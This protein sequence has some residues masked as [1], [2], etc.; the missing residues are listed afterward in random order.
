MVRL[1]KSYRVFRRRVNKVWSYFI[2]QVLKLDITEIKQIHGIKM[3][4]N[5]VEKGGKVY[6]SRSSYQ[7][8]VNPFYKLV[9]NSYMPDLVIDVGANYG[10]TSTLFSKIFTDAKIIAIEPAKNLCKYIDYNSRIND[11]KNITVMRAICDE[12]HGKQKRIS[13]NPLYSQDNRVKAPSKFWRNENV[14]TTSIDHILNENPPTHFLFVKID[15]QGFEYQVFKGARQ[16]LSKQRNWLIKTEFSPFC[17]EEQDTDPALFLEYLIDNY[18]VVDISGIMYFKENKILNLFRNKLY[19]TDINS[20][21]NY[22]ENRDHKKTGWID[23]LVKSKYL[24]T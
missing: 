24:T 15:T 22:T 12:I 7:E 10:F 18:D 8:I 6:L 23:L 13:I 4:V 19:T 20:F 2:I 1:L 5:T 21:I 16:Y 11:S 9:Q 14:I 17:L 3:A